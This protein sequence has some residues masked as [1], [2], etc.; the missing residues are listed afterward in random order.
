M[1]AKKKK[2]AKRARRRRPSPPRPRR[3]RRRNP[4]KRPPRS[5]AKKSKAKKPHQ[6]SRREGRRAQAR[7]PP[8]RPRSAAKKKQIVGEGDYAATAQLP[9]GPGRF[10]RK[11]QGRRS[12]PW[13]RRPKRRWTAGRRSL[14]EAEATRGRPLPRHVLDRLET[15]QPKPPR[16]YLA[17]PSAP[18]VLLVPTA[19]TRLSARSRLEIQRA[20]IRAVA[21]AG[22][23]GAVVEDMAQ[24]AAA[25]GAI[26]LRCAPCHGWCRWWLS[27]AP[28]LVS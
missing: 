28:G 4:R 24:M 27:T 10:C 18:G 3:P 13:A 8:R 14:R 9:Q 2:K 6:E 17:N 1:A 16:V 21:Q 12:R 5:R 23:P 19:L 26:E 11:E 25:I 22:R 15:P 20:A 7:P